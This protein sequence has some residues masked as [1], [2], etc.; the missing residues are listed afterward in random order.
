MGYLD[1]RFFVLD[2]GMLVG[3][4]F[5]GGLML[6]GIAFVVGLVVAGVAFLLI[7]A[8]FGLIYLAAYAI[9]GSPGLSL[10]ASLPA[11]IWLGTVLVRM[12]ATVFNAEPFTPFWQYPVEF[13]WFGLT[14]AIAVGLAVLRLLT[15]ALI[16]SDQPYYL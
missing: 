5:I 6:V 9:T 4:V 1:F 3:Y 8:M 7:A 12:T 14:F 2:M 10:L 11:G 15:R 13:Q 16:G